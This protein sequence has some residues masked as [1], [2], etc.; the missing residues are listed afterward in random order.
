MFQEDKIYRPQ[1]FP[2]KASRWKSM[3]G[4]V[5]VLH[6]EPAFSAAGKLGF[7]VVYKEDNNKHRKGEILSSPL[8]SFMQTFSELN[9]C[10]YA[11]QYDVKF[12]HEIDPPLPPPPKSNPPQPIR[13]FNDE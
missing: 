5:T 6:C 8:S 13:I 7:R 9:E 10:T 1:D 3:F 11:V 2:E 4:K 12:V